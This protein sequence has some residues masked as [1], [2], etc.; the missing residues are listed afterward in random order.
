MLAMLPWPEQKVVKIDA[1]T[2]WSHSLP[3]VLVVG[4]GDRLFRQYLL[5]G[6]ARWTD[7]LLLDPAPI[8]WQQP[9]LI[10]GRCVDFGDPAA[11]LTAAKDLACA[12]QV[13]GVMTWDEK[14]VVPAAKIARSLGVAAMPVKAAVACRDKAEQRSRFESA[15]VPSARHHLVR[16]VAEARAAAAELGYPV[17]IKPRSRAASVGVRAVDGDAELLAALELVQQADRDGPAGYGGFGAGALVEE[18]LRGPEI[19][20]DSWVLDGQ[21]TPF[22]T[23]RKQTGFHPYFV[24]TGHVV[25]AQ[26]DPAV[27][28]KVW[29]VV[30]S[31]NRALGVDRCV[32]HTELVLSRGGPRVV[33]VN[34]RLGGDLI[35]HLR[36]LV[37]PGFSA[38]G[39]AAQVALGT[40]PQNIPDAGG[41]AGIHFVY[42]QSDLRFERLSMSPELSNIDWIHQITQV[43]EPDEEMRVPPGGFL[44]RAAYCVV[45]GNEP[46]SVTKRLAWVA[47]RV[48]AVGA[49][50]D[51]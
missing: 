27:A 40:V 46:V 32:T 28:G 7:V 24:E 17:I 15:G 12:H 18:L 26:L 51:R 6:V 21:V 33:E 45:M 42:P 47:D 34:G 31:A 36:E 50:L 41:A 44:D 16:T 25:E 37:T 48:A 10:D 49:P 39:I 38:G 9:F 23:A 13:N 4:S 19:S 5:E 30:A 8:T 2:H 43:G 11:V 20:V 14:L 35:P 29:S 22:V 3:V 1:G